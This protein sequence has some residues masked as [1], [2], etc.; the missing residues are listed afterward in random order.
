MQYFLVAIV[1]MV[2]N[3]AIAGNSSINNSSDTCPLPAN[4]TDSDVT[5]GPFNWDEKEQARIRI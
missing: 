5:E 2:N 4:S 1:A 3:T